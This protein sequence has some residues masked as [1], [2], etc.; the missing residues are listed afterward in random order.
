[1][2][3]KALKLVLLLAGAALAS[4]RVSVALAA[5][6]VSRRTPSTMKAKQKEKTPRREP[7]PS[8]GKAKPK[9][10]KELNHP[11]PS[12]S[13]HEER[14]VSERHEPPAPIV[15]EAPDEEMLT[16]RHDRKQ[17]F[18]PEPD[19]P[20]AETPRKATADDFLTTFAE[21]AASNQAHATPAPVNPPVVKHRAPTVAAS[22]PAPR[23]DPPVAVPII[24]NKRGQLVV[25]PALKGS[26]EILVRQNEV[27]D[28]EGLG[29]IQDDA[30]LA[31][32]RE[33]KLLVPIPSVSGLQS[34][35]R[36]PANRRYC[37]P[38]TAQ[39]LSALARAHYARFHTALQVNS[40][41]R[42]VEVQERLLMTNGNAAPTEGATAS[43]HLTGQAVD[44]AKHGLSMTEI[45]WLRGYLLP[46]IQAGKLDVEEEFQQSCFH[47]SVY[48]KYSPQPAPKREIAT[49]RHA[50]GLALATAVR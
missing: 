29:R 34:D 21:D 13:R 1:M 40:A 39:F 22:A 41:V 47:I 42:T 30:D 23:P 14:A 3:A 45:A 50:A 11:E 31:S 32:L 37:R 25:P 35:E 8:A 6:P 7:A 2:R 20:E 9:R 43:P 18:S 48:R 24:Y 26:H 49:S 38:W 36:L 4:P 19:A 33:R 12:R 27:A 10:V 5:K 46:L 44:L 16:V 17:H 28:Q 15:R